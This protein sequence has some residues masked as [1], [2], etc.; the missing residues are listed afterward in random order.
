M[1]NMEDKL[2]KTLYKSFNKVKLSDNEQNIIESFMK[3]SKNADNFLDFISLATN[4]SATEAFN[5]IFKN[6]FSKEHI[7]LTEYDICDS[8]FDGDIGVKIMHKFIENICIISPD[9]NEQY[10]GDLIIDSSMESKIV[11]YKAII[12]TMSDGYT[13]E[14]YQQYHSTI[15]KTL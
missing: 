5:K 12:K 8:N 1:I 7:V 15:I 2:K 6:S 9:I 4:Y 3:D 14:R 10:I 11:I 13:N